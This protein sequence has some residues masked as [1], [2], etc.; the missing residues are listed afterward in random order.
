MWKNVVWL[1][2]GFSPGII[3]L[4]HSFYQEIGVP[5]LML[6]A[7]ILVL[8]VIPVVALLTMG[9]PQPLPLPPTQV[10]DPQ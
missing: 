4:G 10:R 9:K 8:I 5:G 6:L 1:G 7:L 3:A 2:L